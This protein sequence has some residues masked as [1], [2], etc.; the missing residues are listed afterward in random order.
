MD[1]SVDQPLDL[2]STLL[3]TL[4]CA[5][6]GG[7]FVAI[8][9]GLLD[10]PP[11]GSAA[12]RFCITTLVL[13]TVARYQRVPIFYTRSA[14]RTILIIGLLFCYANL[15]TYLGT[16]RTTSGRATVFFY[17]QPL[18]LAVLAHYFLLSDPLTLRKGCGLLLAMTGL[19]ALFLNKLT[20]G[21]SSTAL[22]D[23]IVLS[24][25][26]AT[27]VQ[28]L[29]IKRAAGRIHPVALVLWGT[30]ISALFLGVFWWQFEQNA[31]FVFSV[32]AISSV[33]YLSLISA[34]FGFVA[35][36]WLL[37]HN[38]AI[39]VTALVFLVPVFGVLLSWLLLH[40][41]FTNIQLLGIIGVCTGVYIVSSGGTPQVK[42]PLPEEVPAKA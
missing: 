35:F 14:A 5:I 26:L 19:V 6:W 8:K 20:G 2:F 21:H 40:E 12:L 25:A 41:T 22:G 34:A 7:A 29:I 15:T 28:N 27:A 9:I 3:M 38:S 31:H 10:M 37:Q 23:F 1:R 33:L 13:F 39:R 32:R 36:V 18:F 24:G 11:V 4:V 17:T 42:A 30:V 16:A